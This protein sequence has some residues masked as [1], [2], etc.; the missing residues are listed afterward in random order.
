MS[1]S[2]IDRLA[3]GEERRGS[4]N[5]LRESLRRDLE[6]MLNSRRHFFSWPDELEEL[7]RSLVNYGLDDLV[8]ETL[9][10]DEFRDRFVDQVEGLLRR[11]E[12]RIGRFEVSLLPNKNE[13]DRTLR[14]RISGVVTIDG[15]K[16]ELMFDSH[17]DPVRSYLVM[18]G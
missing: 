8:N 2:L 5:E 13:L 14:L 11:L 16:Q 10:A 6:A 3:I 4:V 18:H 1:A 12:S 7:D 15:E 17:L 9:T